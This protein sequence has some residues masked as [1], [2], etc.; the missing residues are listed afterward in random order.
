LIHNNLL[1]VP[2]TEALQGLNVPT[3]G[4]LISIAHHRD[5]EIENYL[6]GY[7]KYYQDIYNKAV[8][9]REAFI[10]A[11]ESA[12]GPDSDITRL[13]NSFYNE[14][15]AD[16]V[17]NVSDK[18]RITEYEGRLV[19]LIDPV[20]QDPQPA[21]V[22]DYRTHFFAP[23]KNLLGNLVSTY[24]FNILVIWFM[25]SVLYAVLYMNWLRKTVSLFGF[26][27]RTGPNRK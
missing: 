21:S 18:D 24:W 13:K 10:S 3:G 7:K 5:G 23:Q 15:L 6:A 26:R 14:S 20:F 27:R 2:E 25:T 16:L 4:K 9:S 8:V 19:Q 22:F 12:S 17:T 1:Q 11:R